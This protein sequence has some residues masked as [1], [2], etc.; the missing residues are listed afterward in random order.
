PPSRPAETE[1]S[2]ESDGAF[3]EEGDE[4][5]LPGAPT[6]EEMR[7][8]KIAYE[9]AAERI[10]DLVRAQNPGAPPL[11][12]TTF[13]HLVQQLYLSALM[14]MGAGTPEGQRPRVDIVGARQTIDLMSILAEKTRGN[15]SQNEERAIQAVLFEL[16]MTFREITRAVTAGP[17]PPPPGMK[18]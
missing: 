3:G 6:V 7:E 10:E 9:E 14:Q 4:M 18:R 13:E 2:E 12:K 8:M 11:E 5:D 16:Y 17:L 1:E 15:L